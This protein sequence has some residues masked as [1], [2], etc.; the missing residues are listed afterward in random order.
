MNEIEKEYAELSANAS[1]YYLDCDYEKIL[2]GIFK[3]VS[4]AND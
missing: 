2:K 1:T 3:E 4:T